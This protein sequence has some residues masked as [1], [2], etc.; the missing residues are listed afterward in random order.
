[1]DFACH[2][3]S[4]FH[5]NMVKDAP[6]SIR[7]ELLLTSVLALQPVVAKQAMEVLRCTPG[8][9]VVHPTPHLSHIP[10][11]LLRLQ[12]SLCLQLNRPPLMLSLPRRRSSLQLLCWN[13]LLPSCGPLRVHTPR[14]RSC[15]PTT[16]FSL[17]A[18]FTRARENIYNLQFECLLSWTHAWRDNP[19]SAGVIHHELY[20]S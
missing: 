17:A 12:P 5:R 11:S 15:P 10:P 16:S 1:M 20:W 14:N 3:W 9:L 6:T 4:E 18:P 19:S 7:Q 13:H 2:I 8:G